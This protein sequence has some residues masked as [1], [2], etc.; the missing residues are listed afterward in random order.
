M[1]EYILTTVSAVMLI[2]FMIISMCKFGLKSCYSAY[3]ALWGEWGDGINEWSFIT[4]LSA[5]LMIPVLLEAAE[6]NPWQ[7]LGFLAPASLFFVAFSPNYKT[8]KLA[9]T[10]HQCGAWCSV[11]FIISYLIL[12][13]HLAWVIIPFSAIAG[14]MSLIY[15]ESRMLWFEIAGYAS[16]YAAMYMMI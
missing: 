5:A 13:P 9:N 8:D 14:I 3:G 7:F 11:L 2:G 15:K 6:G 10:L 4:F 1:W 12:I 16:A